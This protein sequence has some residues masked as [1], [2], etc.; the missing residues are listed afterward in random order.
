MSTALHIAGKAF[1]CIQGIRNKRGWS[2]ACGGMVSRSKEEGP[3]R[4]LYRLFR[5]EWGGDEL[6]SYYS[7]DR[8][9]GHEPTYLTQSYP[10]SKPKPMLPLRVD[11][12]CQHHVTAEQPDLPCT[13]DVYTRNPL[14]PPLQAKSHSAFPAAPL[15]SHSPLQL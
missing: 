4:D 1:C 13:R 15:L 10:P 14:N 6:N 8:R 9:A 2:F 11:A 12:R 7:S 3:G 5:L